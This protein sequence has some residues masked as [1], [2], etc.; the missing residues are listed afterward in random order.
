MICGIPGVAA[1][2]LTWPCKTPVRLVRQQQ[3]TQFHELNQMSRP[4]EKST[5]A[6]DLQQ[7]V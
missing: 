4:A 6:T 5:S 1:K 3:K 7:Q 2:P